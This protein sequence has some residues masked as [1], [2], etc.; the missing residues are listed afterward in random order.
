[1]SKEQIFIGV[2]VA[3]LCV[4]G[5][6]KDRWFLAHT[7]KGKRL[8]RWLGEEKAIWLLRGLFGLGILFGLLLATDIISPV[9]W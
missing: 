1:M 5:L 6:C 3:V 8:I 9:K 7:K 2:T 4:A